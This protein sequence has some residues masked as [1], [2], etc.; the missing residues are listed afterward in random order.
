[1]QALQ[2]VWENGRFWIG[3]RGK[4]V[5]LFWRVDSQ[6]ALPDRS[7]VALVPGADAPL[8]SVSLPTRI[9]GM[10][11]EAVALRQV[12]DLLGPR[13]DTLEVRPARLL[14]RYHSWTNLLVAEQAVAASW[15]RAVAPAG[16]RCL[17]ILPDYMGLPTA[18]H[19]WTVSTV[20]EVGESSVKVRF[21]PHDGFSAE[22][23]L[24]A[25]T[26]SRALAQTDMPAAVLRLGPPVAEIDNVL[27]ELAVVFAP[28]DMPAGVQRPRVFGYAEGQLDLSTD[29]QVRLNRSQRSFS[30]LRLHAVMLL[31]GALA[32]TVGVAIEVREIEGE[33]AALSIRTVEE[34]RRDFLPTSP[35]LD[36]PIQVARELDRR[37]M[38]LRMNEAEERPLL[39]L[40]RAASIMVFSNAVLNRVKMMEDGEIILEVELMD[41]ESLDVVVES[42]RADGLS[43]RVGQS[44]STPDGGV[45]GTLVLAN[46]RSE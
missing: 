42:L 45:I 2:W 24:A 8:I 31:F 16:A 37:R 44:A 21:G 13:F 34:V 46:G 35:I 5:P 7:F 25:F 14:G 1:M 36:I 10:P 29:P 20:C 39:M 12:R 18:P 11:R 3:S 27:G 15:R 28:E 19:V 30:R 6:A 26:I 41:L 22:P 38:A 43:V 23:E 40:Q 32:W 33:T 17:A 4:T 9:R